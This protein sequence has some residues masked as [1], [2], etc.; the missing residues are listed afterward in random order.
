MPLIRPIIFCTRIQGSYQT[1]PGSSWIS[2][3]P[4]L[5]FPI[6]PRSSGSPVWDSYCLQGKGGEDRAHQLKSLQGFESGG[7]TRGN[8]EVWGQHRE[9]ATSKIIQTPGCMKSHNVIQKPKLSHSCISSANRVPRTPQTLTQSL[10]IKWL[11]EWINVGD[12]RPKRGRGKEKEA[13]AGELPCAAGGGWKP[14]AGGAW[15]RNNKGS[16]VRRWEG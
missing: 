15:C 6:S 2:P 12:K 5:W 16:W 9:D 10:N 1:A 7:G 11:S 13:K 8:D 4:D 3:C 14:E